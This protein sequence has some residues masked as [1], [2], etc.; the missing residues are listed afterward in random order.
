MNLSMVMLDPPQPTDWQKELECPVCLMLPR[1][2]PI[3]QCSIGHH[4]CHECYKNLGD[5]KC[6]QCKTCFNRG[7]EPTRNFLAEKLLDYI[8]R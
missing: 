8:E 7:K 5:A 6:P 1:S 4:L 3:Y 2:A